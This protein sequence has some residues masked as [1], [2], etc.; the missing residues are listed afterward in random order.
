M[1]REGLALVVLSLTGFLS[2]AS[3]LP[4]QLG[5][6][7]VSGCDVE[8][9]PYVKA[10]ITLSRSDG[11]CRAAVLPDKLC[12][13]QG[14]AVRFRVVNQCGELIR[15]DQPALK[16]TRPVPK[17]RPGDPP[18]KKEWSFRTCSAQ[19]DTLGQGDEPSNFMF[20]EVP[21]SVE[22]GLYKYGLSG[23]IEPLDP[24]IEV[25]RG[26]GGGGN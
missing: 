13:F 19:F 2:C 6:D 10:Q 9:S 15:P 1:R 22:P 25:R 5:A 21:P 3:H 7:V 14:G 20:C 18:G 12:V 17:S 16:I 8:G 4:P 11:K 23:Q 24:D 26:G